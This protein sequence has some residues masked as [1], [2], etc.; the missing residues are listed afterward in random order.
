MANT[1]VTTIDPAKVSAAGDTLIENGSLMYSQLQ[2]ISDIIE[3]TR[4]HFRGLGGDEVRAQFFKTA[5]HFERFKKF[6]EEYGEFLRGYS[7]THQ[8]AADEIANII[9]TFPGLGGD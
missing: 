3:N 8:A 6:V 9:K 7:Q 1:V 5:E 2:A 4:N